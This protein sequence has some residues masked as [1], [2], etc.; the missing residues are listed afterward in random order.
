MTR[1]SRFVATLRAADVFVR[2]N[3]IVSLGRCVARDVLTSRPRSV[4]AEPGA[5]ALLGGA[6]TVRSLTFGVLLALPVA[7][8]A[9]A[10]AA[11]SRPVMVP[12][13]C[14]FSSSMC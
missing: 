9:S 12:D 5:V 14:M 4:N 10:S 7:G 6:P 3:V 13:R 11:T 2:R 1:P 8:T